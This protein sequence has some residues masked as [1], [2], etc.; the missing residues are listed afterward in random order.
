MEKKGLCRINPK[1][2]F[3]KD[4]PALEFLLFFFYN[5]TFDVDY[6]DPLMLC[7]MCFLI[8]GFL[9]A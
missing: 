6:F 1:G 8:F 9:S 4:C 7:C 5:V 2:Y 3:T